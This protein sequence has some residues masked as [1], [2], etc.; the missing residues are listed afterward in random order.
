[1][2][3]FVPPAGAPVT[4]SL[5]LGGA[6]VQMTL[7]MLLILGVIL[8]AYWML[9]RFGPKFGLKRP[10]GAYGLRLEGHLPLGPKKNIM[11]VRFLNKLLVLGVTEQSINVLTEVDQ[12]DDSSDFASALA[13]ARAA[14]GP[15][16]DGPGPGP[17]P[18][19]PDPA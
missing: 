19:G 6:A 5:G 3:E 15:D 2:A 12:N 18:G 8:L 14:G 10:G 1:M 7:A 17:G 13:G 11:V 4:P 16:P 9:R